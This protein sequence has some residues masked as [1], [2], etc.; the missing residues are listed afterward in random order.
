M[1]QLSLKRVTDRG[2]FNPKY[3]IE[4]SLKPF[5]IKHLQVNPNR[6]NEVKVASSDMSMKLDEGKIKNHAQFLKDEGLFLELQMQTLIRNDKISLHNRTIEKINLLLAM[7][8]RELVQ[9]KKE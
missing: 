6:F 3:D 9:L 5:L 2:D 8:E 4:M 1:Y 7:I